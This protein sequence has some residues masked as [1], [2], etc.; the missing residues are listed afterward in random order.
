MA[1]VFWLAIAPP[2]AAG[3]VL[4]FFAE[5]LLRPDPGAI[6]R[7][8][9]ALAVHLGLW[10][11]GYGLMLASFQRPWFAATAEIALLLLVIAVGNAKNR[12]L[13]EPFV[14]QDFDYFTDALRHPR[15]YIP[16]FG[17]GRTLLAVTA[18][19]LVFWSGIALEASLLRAVGSARFWA[20]CA[21][22]VL[23]GAALLGAGARSRL[24]LSFEPAGDLMRFGL[25]ASLWGYAIA[26]RSVPLAAGH[27]HGFG[28][29][30]LGAATHLPHLVVVQSESFFDARRLH[31]DIRKDV[32]GEFDGVRAAAAGFGRLEVPAWGGSTVRTEFAFLSGL[33]PARL[34]VHRFNPYRKLGRREFPTVA[35]FLRRAGYRTVCVHPYHASFYG[36]DRVFPGLG[37]DEFIDVRAFAGAQGV[38]PFVGDLAVA[39]KIRSILEGSAGPTLVFAITMEN[40][41]PLHLEQAG[42]EDARRFYTAPPPVGF[43]DLTV[44]LRHLSNADRMIG[45]LRECLSRPQTGGWLCWYGDHVPIMPEV[46]DAT[47]FADGRTDYFLWREGRSGAP[48]PPADIAV[49]DLAELLLRSAGLLS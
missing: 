38:D 25:L 45:R 31:P 8:P 49:E 5:R 20:G 21:L 29:M 42:P 36:R 35:D 30:R 47:G 13:R 17:I 9:A 32:L 15:L 40:H 39:E 18:F 41:G 23:A 7:P 34:G 22:V 46:F 48:V 6:A 37:F 14:F 44:Y 28:T 33:P 3:V 4:S 1:E 11:V 27:D 26:E 24:P 12:A 2:L 43:D 16:F 19:A 10:L